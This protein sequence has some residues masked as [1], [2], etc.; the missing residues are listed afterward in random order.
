MCLRQDDKSRL[1]ESSPPAVS[2]SRPRYDPERQTSFH[3][4][5]VWNIVRA[6]GFLIGAEHVPS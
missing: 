4:Q 5:T 2:S 3:L 1:A 6:P